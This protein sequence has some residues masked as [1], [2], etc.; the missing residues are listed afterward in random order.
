M[1][2]VILCIGM[3]F[4]VFVIG[5]LLGVLVLF[6]TMGRGEGIRRKGVG[7]D[8]DGNAMGMGWEWE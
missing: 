4:V 5:F 7:W 3:C 1:V 6:L 2:F 8:C